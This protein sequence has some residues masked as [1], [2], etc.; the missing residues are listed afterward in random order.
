[1][2]PFSVDEDLR[3]YLIAHTHKA[4]IELAH[5][6]R[7]HHVEHELWARGRLDGL[8]T[9]L[10][11]ID[12]ATDNDIRETHR[13]PPTSGEPDLDRSAWVPADPT[14]SHPHR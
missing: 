2:T 4:Y 6:R 3:S 11:A 10:Q 5:A 13:H 8:R 12:P 14:S 7:E 9:I 1:M